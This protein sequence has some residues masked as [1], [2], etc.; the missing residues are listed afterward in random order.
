MTFDPLAAFRCDGKVAVITGGASG[1]GRASAE[2]LSAVGAKVV[3]ADVNESGAKEVVDEIAANGGTAIAHAVDITDKA[4][5][6]ELVQRAVSEFGRLDVMANIAGIASE[7]KVIDLSEEQL[8][9]VLAINLKGTIF[10]CQAALVPMLEQGSGSIINVASASIDV[11]APGYAPYAMTKAAIAQLTKTMAIEYG[12]EGIRVNTISPGATITPFTSRHSYDE[13]G[14]FNQEKYDKF[15]ERMK[16]ISP[17]RMVGEAD[18]QAMIVLYLASD[19][20][21]WATG[22]VWRV[23]GGQAIVS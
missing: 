6:T 20:S 22:Q 16:W 4:A 3:V 21:K 13:D 19:A 23:N 8:D 12:A 15:V 9:K 18:D 11:A 1:I 17:L 2:A 10:G 14:T 7:S 5:V